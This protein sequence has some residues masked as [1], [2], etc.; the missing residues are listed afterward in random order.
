MNIVLIGYGTIASALMPN[1]LT[2]FGRD[3]KSLKVIDPCGAKKPS[4]EFVSPVT[5]VAESI[6]RDNLEE[7]L[8]DL[9][10]ESFVVNLSVDVSSVLITHNESVSLS[11]YLTCFDNGHATY[12]PTINYAYHPCNDAALSIHELSGCSWNSQPD[13]RI[14]HGRDIAFGGDYLGVLLMGHEKMRIGSDLI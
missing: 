13:K 8:C 12:R 1:L 9:D 11:D 6:T 5:W 10:A 14:L 3:I 7:L 4:A 2:E